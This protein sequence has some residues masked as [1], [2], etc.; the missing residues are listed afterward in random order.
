M[1]K[2]A[3]DRLARL[4][5][6]LYFQEATITQLNEVVTTQQRQMDEVEKRCAACEERLRTLMQLLA[7]NGGE[8]NGPPPHYL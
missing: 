6:T 4:E 8:D 3:E 7:D 2:T 1:T 5:E